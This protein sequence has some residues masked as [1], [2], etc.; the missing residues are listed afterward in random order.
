MGEA[1]LAA[2]QVA[3]TRSPTWEKVEAAAAALGL[4]GVKFWRV[5]GDYYDQE[6]AWRRD[7]LGAATTALCARHGVCVAEG[8]E[9]EVL[10]TLCAACGVA[11]LR[12]CWAGA[13]TYSVEHLGQGQARGFAARCGTIRLKTPGRSCLRCPAS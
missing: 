3:Q 7:V 12:R 5:R 4:T 11:P 10:A 1:E 13:C 2:C 8:V 9:S 6:L